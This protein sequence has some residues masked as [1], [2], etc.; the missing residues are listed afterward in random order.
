MVAMT[1]YAYN[2]ALT[3]ANVDES[4]K[5]R[6]ERRLHFKIELRP[7]TR[8]EAYKLVGSI[9]TYIYGERFSPVPGEFVN[10]LYTISQG[11]PGALTSLVN[12]VVSGLAGED[13]TPITKDAEKLLSILSNTTVFTYVG[14]SKAFDR[15]YFEKVL[16]PLAKNKVEEKL[17]STVVAYYYPLTLEEVVALS[18]TKADPEV[19]Q[20]LDQR[21]SLSVAPLLTKVWRTSDYQKAFI[22]MLE[23]LRSVFPESDEVELKRM[24]EELTYPK[25]PWSK[26]Y[27]LVIPDESASEMLEDIISERRA[28]TE[29]SR[30]AEFL[31]RKLEEAGVKLEEAYILSK[32]HAINLYPPPA[33]AAASFI[34]DPQIRAK[35][36]KEA[37]SAVTKG[38]V[39]L[40]RT[41][42][43]LIAVTLDGKIV[44]KT[45]SKS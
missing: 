38:S 7:L 23:A 42:A 41:F 3:L 28:V 27:Y 45:V 17:L 30:F 24:I 32:R 31:K 43:E 34:K 13:C 29:A 5:G 6:T 39:N 11:N 40:D 2:K 19:V 4:L 9:F 22:V 20:V 37:L 14:S 16:L 10:T 33:V 25:D 12:V 44:G 15:I 35:A 18:E 1:P 21:A 26:E 36:W 8:T